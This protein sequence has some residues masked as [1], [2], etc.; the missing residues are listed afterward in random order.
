M[1]LYWIMVDS[2]MDKESVHLKASQ[3]QTPQPDEQLPEVDGKPGLSHC[4][5]LDYNNNS[6]GL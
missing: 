3:S 1:V 4:C 6:I 5:L 2:T